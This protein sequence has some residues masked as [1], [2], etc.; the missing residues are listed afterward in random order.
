[1]WF[2]GLKY[3]KTCMKQNMKL[4]FSTIMLCKL[5]FLIIIEDS[6]FRT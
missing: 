5:K 1:M 2:N 3:T 6:C 4:I